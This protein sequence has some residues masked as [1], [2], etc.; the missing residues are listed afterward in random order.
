MRKLAKSE[1]MLDTAS[2]YGCDRLRHTWAAAHHLHRRASVTE[3]YD[4]RAIEH[5]LDYTSHE[6]AY[7]PGPTLR[8][9]YRQ[10][11]TASAPTTGSDDASP[12]HSLVDVSSIGKHIR[13]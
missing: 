11:R 3:A 6:Q 1:Q 4:S 5:Y 12:R 10:A 8:P 7:R 13:R 9:I 2:V